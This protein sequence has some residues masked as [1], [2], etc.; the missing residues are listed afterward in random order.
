MGWFS[1]DEIVAVDNSSTHDAIQ[2]ISIALLALAA[3]AYGIFKLCNA[4]HRHQSQQ[5]AERAI[6]MANV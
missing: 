6:R 3:L 2:S 4:H 5:V 1:A